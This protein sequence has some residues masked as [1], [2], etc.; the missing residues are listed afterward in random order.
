MESFALEARVERKPSKRVREGSRRLP[1]VSHAAVIKRR[2]TAFFF[3]SAAPLLFFG[4]VAM[5]FT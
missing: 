1:I 4:P 5:S 3:A 2:F